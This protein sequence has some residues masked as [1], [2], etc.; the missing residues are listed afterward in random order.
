MV[1]FPKGVGRAGARSSSSG[2]ERVG[3]PDFDQA[4]ERMLRDSQVLRLKHPSLA[5]STKS[6]FRV[7]RKPDLKVVVFR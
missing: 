7:T 1:D 2:P 3:R 6:V 4:L 5:E